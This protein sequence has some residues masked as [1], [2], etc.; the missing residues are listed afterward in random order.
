M[1]GWAT[2][3]NLMTASLN[4]VTITARLEDREQHGRSMRH[5]REMVETGAAPG[6]MVD[7]G[8]PDEP[9][10]MLTVKMTM[11][12]ESLLAV[13]M[14]PPGGFPEGTSIQEVARDTPP[15]LLAQRALLI[16]ERVV[17]ERRK[18]G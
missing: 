3:G 1:N 6:E 11:D 13:R 5:L 15:I 12:G 7:N 9:G 2:E 16:T 10:L 8:V 14:G 17:R 4:G 18:E